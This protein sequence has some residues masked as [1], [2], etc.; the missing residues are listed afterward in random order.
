MDFGVILITPVIGGFTL[1]PRAS[2]VSIGDGGKM[3]CLNSHDK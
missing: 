2:A 1:A 3:S